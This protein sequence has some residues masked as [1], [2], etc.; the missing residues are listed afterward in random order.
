MKQGIDLLEWYDSLASSYDELYAEEQIMK[1]NVVLNELSSKLG[2]DKGNTRVADLG[3]GTGKL[4]GELIKRGWRGH[5]VGIDLSLNQLLHAYRYLRGVRSHLLVHDL[6]AGDLREPPLRRGSFDIAFSFTVLGSEVGDIELINGL[7]ELIKEGGV[8]TYTML[9]P[10]KGVEDLREF[11]RGFQA[12]LTRFE[13]F[14]TE[15]K[16][17]EG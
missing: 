7:R 12:R 13:S 6:I 8:L 2:E 9:S 1:Y 14:C 15:V 5:Y 4:Y 3:C 10:N 17:S 11:C 16:D